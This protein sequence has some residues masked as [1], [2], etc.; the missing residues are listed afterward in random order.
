MKFA[1]ASAASSIKM[2]KILF[3]NN[4]N[5]DEMGLNLIDE[6]QFNKNNRSKFNLIF[7][8]LIVITI[9]SILTNLF[10]LIRQNS[11]FEIG[12]QLKQL[13]QKFMRFESFKNDTVSI[14]DYNLKS[15]FESN[16][17]LIQNNLNKFD[18]KFDQ[19]NNEQNLKFSA[20]KEVFNS[21]SSLNLKDIGL[22]L[23]TVKNDLNNFIGTQFYSKND[24]DLKYVSLQKS[25]N[26]SINLMIENIEQKFDNFKQDLNRSDNFK[27]F[28]EYIKNLNS[29][30]V[31]INS[32]IEK[33][34]LNISDNLQINN[35]SINCNNNE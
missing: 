25:L 33:K 30:F 13:D 7:L 10:Y 9:V 29:T 4:E 18:K 32:L 31:L 14:I 21:S 24:Q 5:N 20:I 16:L 3:K 2:Q 26:S 28:F 12:N 23:N 22:I 11:Q 15:V 34:I 27:E 6:K 35:A 1:A 8:T 19:I 17:N